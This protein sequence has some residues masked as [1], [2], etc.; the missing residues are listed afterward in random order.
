MRKACAQA[1]FVVAQLALDYS[2]VSHDLLLLRLSAADDALD[3]GE[4]RAGA[5]KV[6]RELG[7]PGERSC[8]VGIRCSLRV[9]HE[10]KGQATGDAQGDGVRLGNEGGKRFEPEGEGLWCVLTT[11]AALANED[12]GTLVGCRSGDILA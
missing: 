9:Q 3:G 7:V 12:R 5:V 4:D 8:H 1:C 11:V 10:T 6:T 2:Q